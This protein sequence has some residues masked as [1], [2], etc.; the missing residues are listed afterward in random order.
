M[1]F[2]INKNATEDI[3]VG[4]FLIIHDKGQN[5]Q[6]RQIIRYKGTYIGLDVE[7]GTEGFTADSIECL[8]NC[9]KE[10]YDIVTP[11]KN[12][13]IEIVIGGR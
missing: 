7:S 12:A 2:T 3:K 4:D 1:K 9:Y 13:D 11:V 8:V 10:G 5:P 6:I